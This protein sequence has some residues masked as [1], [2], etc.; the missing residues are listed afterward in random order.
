MRRCVFERRLE[1]ARPVMISFDEFFCVS[2]IFSHHNKFSFHYCLSQQSRQN[3]KTFFV[4]TQ[5]HYS[6]FWTHQSTASTLGLRIIKGK[7]GW[8]WKFDQ[9]KRFDEIILSW[10]NLP[11]F[12]LPQFS[13][14]T[15]FLFILTFFSRWKLGHRWS[16]WCAQKQEPSRIKVA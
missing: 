15:P 1:L 13:L 12:L 10:R 3:F 9:T 14:P 2:L 4:N 5:L 8:F 6:E 11:S 7:N 16:S